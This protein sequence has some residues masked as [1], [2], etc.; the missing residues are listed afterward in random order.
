MAGIPLVT[1][2]AVNPNRGNTAMQEF[3][4]GVNSLRNDIMRR[5]GMSDTGW[6]ELAKHAV[7]LTGVETKNGTSIRYKVKSLLPDWM[8]QGIQLVA[9]GKIM[10]VSRGLTQIKYDPWDK[11]LKARYSEYEID[12]DSLK[13]SAFKQGQAT[14]IRLDKNREKTN[15]PY[16][17]SD[18]TLMSETDKNNIFWNRGKLTDRLNDR[19]DS[20][21]SGV[22]YIQNYNKKKIIQ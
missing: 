18:N 7:N 22:Q 6:A 19:N 17:W 9:R 13:D 2:T 10:P 20:N 21:N 12:D 14:V 15:K 11:E 3:I 4:R 8:L 16:R 1:V 5:T